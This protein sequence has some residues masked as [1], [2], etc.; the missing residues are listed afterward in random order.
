M[1]KTLQDIL[2]IPLEVPPVEI[3]DLIV[4]ATHRS[5]LKNTIMQK[6]MPKYIIFDSIGTN[7]SIRYYYLL[8]SMP[9]ISSHTYNVDATKLL[10]LYNRKY[11][12]SKLESF[13]T[14]RKYVKG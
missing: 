2:G 4:S 14:R 6:A 5:D 10:D 13:I 3:F 7:C 8:P 9:S 11:K 12:Q 1:F